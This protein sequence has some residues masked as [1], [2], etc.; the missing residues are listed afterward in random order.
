MVCGMDYIKIRI[1]ATLDCILRIDSKLQLGLSR[2]NTAIVI[3]EVTVYET[4]AGANQQHIIYLQ[5]AYYYCSM[6]GNDQKLLA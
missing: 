4:A 5:V 3:K 2:S 6:F 1:A